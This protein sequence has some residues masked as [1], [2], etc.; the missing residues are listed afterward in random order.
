MKQKLPIEW[1]K[2]FNAALPEEAK[3][4]NIAAVQNDKVDYVVS[5]KF[6]GAGVLYTGRLI[7]WR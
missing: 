5:N 2:P 7:N 4:G 3:G 6:V 1:T